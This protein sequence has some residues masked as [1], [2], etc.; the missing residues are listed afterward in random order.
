MCVFVKEHV[1]RESRFGI[2]IKRIAHFSNFGP[3]PGRD[4][5]FHP[6]ALTSFNWSAG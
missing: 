1:E 5:D 4:L 3:L 6:L 2:R